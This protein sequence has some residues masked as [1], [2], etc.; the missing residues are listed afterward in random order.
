MRLDL[1]G[2]PWTVKFEARNGF[3]DRLSRRLST[4]VLIAGVTISLLGFF[5]AARR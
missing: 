5:L 1:A 3:E 4:V 2:R